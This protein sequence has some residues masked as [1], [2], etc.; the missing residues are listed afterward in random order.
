VICVCILI[1][2]YLK[3]YHEEKMKEHFDFGSLIIIIITFFLFVLALFTKGFTHDLLL[4]AGV[5]L[6]S[7]KLILISY[8]NSVTSKE[9]L[10]ELKAIRMSLKN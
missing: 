1:Y 8:K 4:E 9:L 10:S 3:E 6:I 5:F 2:N 7:I